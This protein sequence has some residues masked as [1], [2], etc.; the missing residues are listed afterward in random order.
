MQALHA[1]LLDLAEQHQPCTVR[2]LYYLAIST[3]LVPKDVGGRKTSYKL[4]Q[5]GVLLLRERGRMPWGWVVDPSRRVLA[6]ESW[7]GPAQLLRDAA[8]WYRLN[9]WSAQPVWADVWCESESV[10]MTLQDVTDRWRVSLRPCKGHPS[11]PFVRE[12]VMEYRSQRRAQDKPLAV[13]Y[14]GDF[15][16]TGL[17]IEISLTERLGRYS[18]GLLRDLVRRVG[19]TADQVREQGLLSHEANQNSAG[20][21]LEAFASECARAGIAEESVEVEAMDPDVLRGLLDADLAALIDEDAWAASLEQEQED[22]ARLRR[23][24][25]A[26]DAA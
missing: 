25:D 13:L 23:L 3:G 6:A 9:P 1:S 15:D 7:A 21:D 5:E 18:F 2:Q 22:R 8:G 10:A 4:V 26:W 14:I 19:V 24:A 16:P 11:A 17:G 20:R 12:A